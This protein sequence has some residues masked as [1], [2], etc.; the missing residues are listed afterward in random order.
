MANPPR[1]RHS[2]PRR[3]PVTIDLPP[4][5]VKRMEEERKEEAAATEG[6]S[7]GAA[8][9]EP[10]AGAA[11]PE[12]GAA[13][14]SEPETAEESRNQG[15]G[16]VPPGRSEYDTGASDG[17]TRSGSGRVWAGAIGGGIVGA[18]V[19]VGAAAAL[20]WYGYLP[21]PQDNVAVL[22][23]EVEALRANPAQLNR[24]DRAAID[25]ARQAAASAQGQGKD[26]HDAIGQLKEQ[27]ASLEKT[28]SA[29]REPAGQTGAGD[30]Q[31]L[32]KRVGDVEQKIAALAQNPAPAP[33]TQQSLQQLSSQLQALSGKVSDLAGSM[34]QTASAVSRDSNTVSATAPRSPLSGHTSIPSGRRSRR[35][36]ASRES[37]EPSPLRR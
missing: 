12:S 2:K 30:L 18:A 15:D 7:L 19:A 1:N 10:Q 21:V 11:A 16:T 22:R 24:Q 4:S 23:Q 35:A 33:A 28:V 5:E 14:E 36:P 34:Q 13:A 29:I 32:Q 26:A 20:Q 27:I 9:V 31:A 8:T 3:D 6:Q 17:R 25:Q 37:R